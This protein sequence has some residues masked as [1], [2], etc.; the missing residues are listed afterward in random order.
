MQGR[1]QTILMAI[2]QWISITVTWYHLLTLLH[3]LNPILR[4][5]PIIPYV[6]E[7]EITAALEVHRNDAFEKNILNN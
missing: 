6:T 5:F 1:S 3:S 2:E 7:S 4:F